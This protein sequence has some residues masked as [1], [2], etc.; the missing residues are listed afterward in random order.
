MGHSPPEEHGLA[1]LKPRIPEAASD[2]LDALLIEYLRA[3]RA[4]I[5]ANT[6]R[7][8][9]PLELTETQIQLALLYYARRG[10]EGE[11]SHAE[12]EVRRAL[13]AGSD[14]IPQSILDTLYAWRL[15]PCARRATAEE[16]G[17]DHAPL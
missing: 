14:D 10:I 17:S 5:L 4:Y 3:A 15:L 13:Y 7:Q 6:G 11:Q 9:L 12:G 8:R 2:D 16:G 1:R